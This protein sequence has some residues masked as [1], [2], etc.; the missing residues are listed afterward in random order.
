MAKELLVMNKGEELDEFRD[1][2]GSDDEEVC[3]KAV[4]ENFLRG[5]SAYQPPTWRSLIH[6]LYL[7]GETRIAQSI[8]SYAEPVEGE[9]TC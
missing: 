8:I 2:H 3:L 7:I 6:V 5:E 9:S 4:I 1:Q